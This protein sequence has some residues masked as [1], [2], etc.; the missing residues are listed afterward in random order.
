MR[1]PRLTAVLITIAAAAACNPMA[2]DDADPVRFASLYRAG[3]EQA[4]PLELQA[5]TTAR[6][7]VRFL[8]EFGQPLRGLRPEHA[9]TLVFQP[10]TLASVTEAPDTNGFFFDVNVT[11]AVGARGGVRIGYGEAGNPTRRTFGPFDVVVE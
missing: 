11:G 1:I 2:D 9:A 8:D 10:A 6:I 4:E 5:G 7:E 3:V